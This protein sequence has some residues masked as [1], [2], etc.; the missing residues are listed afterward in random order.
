VIRERKGISQV[1]LSRTINVSRQA[2]S[3]IE[4][5]KQ[6]PSLPVAL[7]IAQAL[8]TP[9]QQIFFLEDQS[10]ETAKSVSLTK[11]ERLNF[12]NQFRILQ[13]IHHDDDIEVKHY[14]Y[15]EEIFERGY[16]YLYFECFE[17]LWDAMPTEV[18][19][20]VVDILQMHRVL[21]HSLGEK[22]SPADIERVKFLGFDGNYESNYLAFGRFYT[23]DG[24][25]FEEIKVINSHHPTLDGYRKM[26]AEWR[27]MDNKH[28]L[29]KAQIE[30]ILEAGT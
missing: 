26:L 13:A 3:A 12:V 24:E 7:K 29:S 27:R 8:D 1:D 23:K 20:E 9:L 4:T 2:L 11:A 17:H 25:R 30:S 16:E 14:R 10:M 18:A 15:L 5:H 28:Q 6:D 19:E 21:L 22:P